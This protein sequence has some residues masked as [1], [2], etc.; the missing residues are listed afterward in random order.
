MKS[1][2]DFVDDPAQFDTDLAPV[3]LDDDTWRRKLGEMEFQVLR[4]EGTERAFSNDLNDEK[5]RGLFLCRGCGLPLFTSEQKFDSDSE[6]RFAVIL[7][8]ML[9]TGNSL[10]ATIDL[11]KRAGCLDIRG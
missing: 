4:D 6:R 5:R 3:E 9:A 1:W 11:L 2:H 10:A 7:D 8:P